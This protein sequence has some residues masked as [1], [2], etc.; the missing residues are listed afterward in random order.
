MEIYHFTYR[1]SVDVW[2]NKSL[3]S[4]SKM[5]IYFQSGVPPDYFSST[6]QLWGTPTYFWAKHRRTNFDWWRRRFKRQFELAD[7]LR[8]DHFR[9][10]AGYWR[11]QG[12]SKTAI[13]GKW[14]NSPGKELL[15]ELKKDLKVD[16]LPIIAEDLGVITPE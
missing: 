1:D 7:I 16:Y 4:I 10:L 12:N 8:L 6:G 3:F 14:I 9:A 15:N 13:D 11:V 2:S 5:E